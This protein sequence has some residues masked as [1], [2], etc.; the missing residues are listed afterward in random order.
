MRVLVTG[1]GTGGHVYPAL[2]VIEALR[3]DPRWGVGADDVAWVGSAHSV[4][5]RILAREGLTFLAISAGALRGT[6]PL[7]ALRSLGALRRGYTEARQV[8][9]QFSPAVVLATGGYVSVPLV[10]AARAAR[11]PVM[12]YL[13]DMEPGLAVKFLSYWVQRVAVS[14]DSVA[15]YF[16]RRK[17]IVSGYPVRAKLFQTAKDAACQALGLLSDWP[18]LLVFGGSRGAHAINAAVRQ[19]L[20]SLLQVAQ[21]VHISGPEEY[22]SLA[23]LRADLASELQGRYHLY[24]Y[25]YED[26]TDALAAADLVVARAGAATLGEFP[27]VGL[28]AIL[29]PY[30][31]AGQH[32]QVNAAYLAEHGAGLILQDAELPTQLWPTIQGLLRDKARLQAMSIASRTL[33]VPDAAQRIAAELSSLAQTRTQG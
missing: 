4:E 26:M 12:I 33:A 8:L 18:T 24:A 3:N 5:E 32:Q 29:V 2:A 19:V 23:D 11:C 21:V 16:P 14:F 22:Q 20:T 28:P 25:M 15:T 9:A 13:P 1:G 27:A 31:Y 10:L 17:V 6:N 7:T 30:P